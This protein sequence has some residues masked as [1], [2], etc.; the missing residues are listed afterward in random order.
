M[1]DIYHSR[2]GHFNKCA[3]YLR[4]EDNAISDLNEYVLKT[5]PTGYFYARESNSLAQS[6]NQVNN[7]IMIDRS[8]INIQTNDDVN[9]LI[10]G[11][12]VVYNGKVWLVDNLQQEIHLKETEFSQH[13]HCTTYIALRR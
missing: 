12:I 9:G 6:K 1:I 10:A 8:V 2:R 11:S 5:T 13:K 7:A 4:E 3:Y